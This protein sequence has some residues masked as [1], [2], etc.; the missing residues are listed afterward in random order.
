[1]PEA[2]VLVPDTGSKKAHF[3]Q[4]TIGANDV[5]DEYVQ[6]GEVGLPSY[7]ITAA[8]VAT[9]T[10]ASHMLQAMAGATLPVRLRRVW[11]TQNG[12][13][14]AVTAFPLQLVRVIT[15]GT[16]GTAVTARPFDTAAAAA[17][18]AGMTLPTVKGTEGVVL[19]DKTI[20]LG[21]AA[22]PVRDHPLFWE[23]Q[24]RSQPIIIPA[25]TA[26]GIVLKNTAG[27]ATSTLSIV[28]EV[29][30]ANFV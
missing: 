26:N 8:A 15:A 27:V 28:F 5:L 12:A 4:R 13:P 14:G 20:W 1:M 16:G 21:T 23:E 29:T 22:I 11:V 25:G 17:G 3:W 9:T 18:A 7:F 6:L 24:P 30:E 10:A 2:T 19:F